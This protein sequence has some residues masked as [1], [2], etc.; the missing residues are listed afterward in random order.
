MDLFRANWMGSKEKEKEAELVSSNN[1]QAIEKLVQFCLL[2]IIISII[3]GNLGEQQNS[4]K[5]N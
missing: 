4:N 3:I 2:F 1:Q 5:T